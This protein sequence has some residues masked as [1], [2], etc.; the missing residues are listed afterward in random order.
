[1]NSKNKCIAVYGATGHTGQFVVH[2]VQRRGLPVAAVGRGAARLDETIPPAVPRHIAELDDP[3]SLERAFAGCA[4]V[5]NCAGPFLDTAAPVA[6]AALRAGCHYIDVTAEQASAHASFTD[7]DAPARTANRVVIPAAGFYGGLADLVASALA[8]AGDIDEITVAIAL[9]HWWPT[10]GTRKTGERNIVPRVVVKNG[11]LA[12]LAPSGDVPDWAF[13]SPLGS[14]PMIEL[15]FSEI[16]TLIHHLK[17][18]EIRSLLNR[19]ALDDIR[20]AATPPPTAVDDSGRSAQRFELVVCLMQDGMTKTAG[21]RGKDIYAVTA[22]IVTEAALRL[23]APSYRRS[24]ALALAEAVD[25]IELLRSLHGSAL[26]L[27]GDTLR[28]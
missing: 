23:L 16:I 20:D 4:V 6:R 18:G 13:S 3:V 7:F 17:V 15:P 14:Q 2:E 27:F 19:S 8:S 10:A 28:G 26:D 1:M 25:P 22:P 9:D 12:P 5:I 24:G 21:V 11:R